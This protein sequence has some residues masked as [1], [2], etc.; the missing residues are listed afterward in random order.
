[1]SREF[2]RGMGSINL[3]P[4]KREIKIAPLSLKILSDEEAFK[5]D[6]EAVGKDM[7]TAIKIIDLQPTQSNCPNQIPPCERKS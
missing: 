2:L 3:F 7:W 4:N 1:M 6:L 5:A